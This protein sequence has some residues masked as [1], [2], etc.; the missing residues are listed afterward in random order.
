MDKKIGRI[1]V[2]PGRLATM[3]TFRNPINEDD[4][5]HKIIAIVMK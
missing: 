1:P 4:D 3:V 5:D 2:K